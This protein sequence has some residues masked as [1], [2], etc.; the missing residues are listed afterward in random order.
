MH[1]GIYLH[2]FFS[3]ALSFFKKNSQLGY[4]NVYCFLCNKGNQSGTCITDGP[5]KSVSDFS[6][7]LNHGSLT[8]GNT[9]LR[10]KCTQYQYHDRFFVSRLTCYMILTEGVILFLEIDQQIVAQMPFT[11]S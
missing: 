2:I 9:D 5:F 11:V 10:E 8:A 6:F 4:A 7:L 1:A 3:E